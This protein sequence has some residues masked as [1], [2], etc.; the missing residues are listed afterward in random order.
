MLHRTSYIFDNFRIDPVKRQLFYHGEFVPLK[1]IPFDLLLVFVENPGRDLSR[2]ELINVVWKG[3][4]VERGTFDVQLSKV[5]SALREPK[6]APRYIIKSS[7]GYRFVADLRQLSTAGEEMSTGKRVFGAHVPSHAAHVIGVGLVYGCYYVVSLLLEVTY[8]FERF[9]SSALKIAP[10]VFISMVLSAIGSL[11]VDRRLTQNGRDNGLLGS[12]FCLL[13]TAG[14]LFWFMMQFLPSFPV[15]QSTLPTYPA[16]AAFLKNTIYIVFL[17]VLFVLLPFH[18]IVTMER[19]FPVENLELGN[20]AVRSHDEGQRTPYWSFWALA[21]LLVIFLVMSITMTARLLDNL[22]PNPYHNLFVQLVYVRALL[23]FGLGI[24]CLVW[25]RSSLNGIK[26][27][28]R[29]LL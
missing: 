16:Q 15:T 9:G 8:R 11:E 5:R 18:F 4:F 13:L 3:A 26:R 27:G 6:R 20:V 22:K 24:Y 7:A 1:G 28:N 19:R 10:L 21:I 2:D 29:F 23:F 25:Y 17:A 12:A 14:V